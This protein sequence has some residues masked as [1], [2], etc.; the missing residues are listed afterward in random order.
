MLVAQRFEP[1]FRTASMAVL[2]PG[3]QV[4]P[5]QTSRPTTS[6]PATR[7]ATLDPSRKWTLRIL[8]RR[9]FDGNARG[10]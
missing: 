5:K 2:E 4:I 8:T 6:Y 9:Q 7:V 3:N 10:L 1:R